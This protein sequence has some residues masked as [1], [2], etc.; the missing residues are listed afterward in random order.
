MSCELSGKKF[1][2]TEVEFFKE[3]GRP[4]DYIKINPTGAIPM[5]QEG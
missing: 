3:G 5:I 4:D 2:F 1:K